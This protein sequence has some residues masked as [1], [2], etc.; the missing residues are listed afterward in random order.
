MT[1]VELDAWSRDRITFDV[2]GDF[3]YRAFVRYTEIW[4]MSAVFSIATI[5]RGLTGT[6][7]LGRSLSGM[8]GSQRAALAR[9]EDGSWRVADMR[10]LYPY[11]KRWP[12]AGILRARE[13]ARELRRQRDAEQA[14]QRT[15]GS[16]REE[17][18]RDVADTSQGVS[19]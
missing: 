4:G 8:L 16:S 1:D 19:S 6:G 11:I 10:K 15:L 9:A 3:K 13:I 17:D 5:R 12:K 18:R 2:I 14:H 7:R